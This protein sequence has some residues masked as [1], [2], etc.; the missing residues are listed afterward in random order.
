VT[1]HNLTQVLHTR[2][3]RMI[4]A[5]HAGFARNAHRKRGTYQEHSTFCDIPMLDKINP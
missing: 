3:E 5:A 2:E 1:R 4:Q